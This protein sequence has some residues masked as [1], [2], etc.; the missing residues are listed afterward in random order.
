MFGELKEVAWISKISLSRDRENN[1]RDRFVNE[2]IKSEYPN[3]IEEFDNLL[4]CFQSRKSTFVENWF[5]KNIKLDRLFV[6]DEVSGLA[7]H[8]ETFANF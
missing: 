4:E 1:I 6:M 2:N 8:S 3:S 5:G 7:D